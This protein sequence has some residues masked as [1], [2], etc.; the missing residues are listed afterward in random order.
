MQP[1]PQETRLRSPEHITRNRG[2][3]GAASAPRR[4]RTAFPQ[5]GKEALPGALWGGGR[6]ARGPFRASCCGHQ[7]RPSPGRGHTF[8]NRD[9]RAIM[10]GRIGASGK[11][12]LITVHKTQPTSLFLR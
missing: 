3:L 10:S 4:Q 12:V 11:R 5:D 8:V 6:A 1:D 9:Y 2:R 7:G